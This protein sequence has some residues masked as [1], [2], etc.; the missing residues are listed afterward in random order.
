MSMS[1][2]PCD[3]QFEAIFS[4]SV[5]QARQRERAAFDDAAGA[6]AKSLVLYGAG[7]L[8]R[9]VLRGLRKNGLDAMAFADANPTL[10]GQKI[11]GVRIAP[12]YG[13]PRAGDVRDSQA[14]TTLAVAELGHSPRYSFEDGLRVTLE[15][16]RK[17]HAGAA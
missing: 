2:S 8:G 6:H 12:V 11:E 3:E 15:W 5:E 4:E 7:N 9:M 14:D 13:P 16:Y 10:R 17:Q 1:G